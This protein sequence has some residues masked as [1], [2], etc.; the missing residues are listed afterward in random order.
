MGCGRE[1]KSLWSQPRLSRLG[2][3]RS[4]PNAS[5]PDSDCQA[6]EAS[7]EREE[8]AG[9]LGSVATEEAGQVG[10]VH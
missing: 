3:G 7:S 4:R 9:L 10:L 6:S 5:L 8:A 2:L 1:R